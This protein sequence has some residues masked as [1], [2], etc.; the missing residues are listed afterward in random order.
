VE[1]HKSKQ[2]QSKVK[3]GRGNAEAREDD[4]NQARQGKAS[5]GKASQVKARQGKARQG[6]ARQGKARQGKARQG[7]ARRRHKRGP[8]GGGGLPLGFQLLD[9]C[10]PGFQGFQST[11]SGF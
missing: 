7:K 4:R 11:V 6:K 9:L 8:P 1:Q 3:E 2:T 5:Q 10:I